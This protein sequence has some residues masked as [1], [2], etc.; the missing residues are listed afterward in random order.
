MFVFFAKQEELK[1]LDRK[2]LFLSL[3]FM[4]QHYTVLEQRGEKDVYLAN[5]FTQRN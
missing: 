4:K 1:S 2:H 3:H 5:G